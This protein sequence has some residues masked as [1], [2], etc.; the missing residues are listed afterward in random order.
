MSI[1][2]FTAAL[3]RLG[4]S[5]KGESPQGVI[6]SRFEDLEDPDFQV[7]A[8]MSRPK[9]TRFSPAVAENKD[10][11]TTNMLNADRKIVRPE[12]KKSDARA[13]E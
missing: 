13:S 3:R 12:K 8:E 4:V 7:L 6:V 5:V 1:E 9:A 2:R 11:I 10:A